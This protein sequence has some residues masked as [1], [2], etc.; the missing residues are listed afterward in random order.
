MSL[1][2]SCDAVL[3]NFSCDCFYWLPRFEGV[4]ICIKPQLNSF[5]HRPSPLIPTQVAMTCSF[6]GN[7]FSIWVIFWLLRLF[8]W[9]SRKE[10]WWLFNMWVDCVIELN[11][12]RR[13]ER[14][15]K[16]C[17]M[18]ERHFHRKHAPFGVFGVSLHFID[19][20]RNQLGEQRCV[21]WMRRPLAPA[22][23]VNPNGL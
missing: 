23:R 2:L 21:D 8:F 12:G 1:S 10:K 9:H 18:P 20:L 6:I 22:A 19:L 17:C 4:V 3:L 14:V 15:R 11:D 5:F 13:R 16:T 7:L